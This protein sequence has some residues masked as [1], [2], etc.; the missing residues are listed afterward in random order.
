MIINGV[1]KSIDND[2][3]IKPIVVKG[4]TM[5]PLRTLIESMGGKISWEDTTKTFS[6][7]VGDKSIEM[8]IGVLLCH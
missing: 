8:S 5:I 4:R 1:E 2:E 7:L 6:I 3:A